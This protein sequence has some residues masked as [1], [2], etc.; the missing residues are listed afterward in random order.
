MP[1]SQRSL[2]I[3]FSLFDYTQHH[4]LWAQ[5]I[6]AQDHSLSQIKASQTQTF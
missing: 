1:Y 3:R 4:T 5:K 6:G 2:G